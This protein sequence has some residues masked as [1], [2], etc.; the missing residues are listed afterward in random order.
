MDRDSKYQA[1]SMDKM[2]YMEAI[3]QEH[4]LQSLEDESVIIEEELIQQQM[5]IHQRIQSTPVEMQFAFN[6]REAIQKIEE[7]KKSQRDK[8]RESL[9]VRSSKR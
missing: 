7:K 9:S 3:G 1:K 5:K 6:T 8:E 4:Q 2:P